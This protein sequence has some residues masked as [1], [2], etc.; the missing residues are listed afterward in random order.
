MPSPTRTQLR[1]SAR[2]FLL[3]TALVAAL[4]LSLAPTPL[5]HAAA[6]TWHLAAEL[7]TAPHQANPNPDTLG[8]ANVWYF[9]ESSTLAHDPQ[10]YSLLPEFITDRFFIE[11]LQGWQGT[12]VGTSIKDKLPSVTIN[13]TGTLQTPHGFVW[14]DGVVSVHPL[15]DQLVIVGWRSPITGAVRITG[16]ITDIDSN[17]GDGVD[18][19]I[20]KGAQTVAHGSITNGG[21][22]TFPP[23]TD[24]L[25]QGDFLYFI[26]GPKSSDN[27]CDSTGLEVRISTERAWTLKGFSQPVDM[28][29]T[30]TVKN[31]S[32][33][34]LKFEVFGASELTDPAVVKSISAVAVNCTSFTP[35]EDPI[36]EIAPTG[37]TALRY[38]TTGGQFIYNWKTPSKGG[39]C[40]NV[41]MTTQ[42][43]STL[44]AN[45][46]LK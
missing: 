7:R 16:G 20:D 38:D 11:G 34:P 32:T 31:G 9:L 1:A 43:G 10:T 14:P 5:A 23:S 2:P 39:T 46:K 45:F 40:Y 19:F 15:P 30:N 29:V 28:G 17:C 13:A 22:Q 33:V 27:A 3:L 37:G 41:T 25:S 18:W 24:S 26:V 42:D 44:S 8:N 6:S 12:V 21:A 35:G 4:V 36:D